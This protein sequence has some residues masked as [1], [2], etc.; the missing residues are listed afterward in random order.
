M[1]G[2]IYK[3]QPYQEHGRLLFTYTPQGKV[4]LLAQGS[5]K[6]NQVSRILAQ[7]LTK[8]T[9]KEGNKSFMKLQE[10]AIVED[11]AAIKSD[12]HLTQTAA[13]MLEIIDHIVVDNADHVRI[14]HELD[15]AL[16]APY[17]ELSSLSFAL[18]MTELLGY[19]LDLIPDGRTLKGL[20]LSQ[21]RLIYQDETDPVDV[22]ISD[23]LG[24]LKFMKMPYEAL[25][26]ELKIY[27]DVVKNF[28]S[29]Y[30]DYHLQTTLKNLQ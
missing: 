1:E 13:L 29:K 14:Y 19:G 15:L 27:L 22:S 7:Y 28:V 20:S 18:K 12:Y 10:G 26:P 6:L 4:T 11:F 21:G 25:T 30:Y 8:I 23:A 2:I 24:I 3:V 5:Q 9:F 17:I 16:H